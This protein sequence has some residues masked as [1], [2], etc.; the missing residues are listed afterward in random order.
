MEQFKYKLL[1]AYDGT[2]Y[3]GYQT[4]INANTI[5]DQIEKALQ[6]LAKGEFVRIH[7]ASRTDAGVH[8]KGQ[9]AHFEFP[10][11]ITPEGLLKG[12]N[13][14]LP[15]AI[16]IQDV[17]RVKPEFHSR[18]DVVGK[19]Y[20]YR[21][22]NSSLKNPFKRHF[23]T[24]HPYS[25]NITKAQEA[26]K[27][28]EGTYDFSS[29]SASNTDVVDKVRT[30]YGASVKEDDDEWVFTFIGDG[31]L[32]NMIRIIVGTIIEVAEGKRT[33]ESI[34]EIIEAKNRNKAGKTFPSTGLCL[35]EIYYNKESMDKEIHK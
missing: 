15:D 29:F 12:L 10:F 5:Q 26:L 9:V 27:Y 21:V 1:I 22:L 19:K 30:I 35:V 25:K 23:T 4:Q 16:V 33:P 6:K 17:E 31:F 2:P 7:A 20:E 3:A 11:N 18:Y 24:H 32:Y 13:T 14:L 8:A 34:K 28:L